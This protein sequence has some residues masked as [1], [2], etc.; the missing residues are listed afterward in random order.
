LLSIASVAGARFGEISRQLALTDDPRTDAFSAKGLECTVSGGHGMGADSVVKA[1]YFEFWYAMGSTGPVDSVE[2]NV[3][4]TRLFDRSME[5]MVWCT[6]ITDADGGSV[7]HL[8]LSPEQVVEKNGST[9]RAR[10]LSIIA[11]NSG[12]NDVTTDCKF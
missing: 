4:E 3:L 5:G 10:E 11:V 6:S 2:M 8:Q 9:E 12:S 1:T 7:R